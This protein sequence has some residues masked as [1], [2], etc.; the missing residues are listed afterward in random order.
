MVSPFPSVSRGDR[1][2][3]ENQMTTDFLGGHLSFIRV[4]RRFG[5]LSGITANRAHPCPAGSN[6]LNEYRM[7]MWRKPE[8]HRLQ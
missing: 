4:I 2:E 7:S 5:T 1:K 3:A 6:P 8:S